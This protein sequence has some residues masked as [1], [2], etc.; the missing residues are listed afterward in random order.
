MKGGGKKKLNNRLARLSKD[1][2]FAADKNGIFGNTSQGFHQPNTVILQINNGQ[3]SGA[4]NSK[5]PTT[6]VN[7][8]MNQYNINNIS[9]MESRGGFH[10]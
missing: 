8:S 1:G 4:L 5:R 7:T 3:G 2:L 9:V 6:G 10:E